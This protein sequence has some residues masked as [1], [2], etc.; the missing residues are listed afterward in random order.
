MAIEW[1]DIGKKKLFL[2]KENTI[3]ARTMLKSHL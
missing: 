3:V 2:L 1:I